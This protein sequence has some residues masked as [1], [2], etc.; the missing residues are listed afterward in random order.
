[1]VSDYVLTQRIDYELPAI[2]AIARSN[3]ALEINTGY[4]SGLNEVYPSN[5]ILQMVANKNIPVLV[6]NDAHSVG[7]IGHNFDVAKTLIQQYKL[8]HF[9]YVK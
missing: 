8:V 7:Q 3:G 4:K 1:M 2:E 6:S 5:R 9:Q